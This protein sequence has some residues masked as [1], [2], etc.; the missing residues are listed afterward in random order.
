M[1]G[2]SSTGLPRLVY[3]YLSNQGCL[4]HTFN[5]FTLWS[6]TMYIVLGFWSML[7]SVQKAVGLIIVLIVVFCATWCANS[8]LQPLHLHYSS[9]SLARQQPVREALG[10]ATWCRNYVGFVWLSAFAT[11]KIQGIGRGHQTGIQVFL[12]KFKRWP[13]DEEKL[14]NVQYIFGPNNILSVL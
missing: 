10:L 14:L 3:V 12:G 13:K 11:D 9:L 6:R 2:P 1:K 8:P 5:L 4:D 7:F